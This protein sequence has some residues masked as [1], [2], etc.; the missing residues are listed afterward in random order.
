LTVGSDFVDISLCTNLQHLILDLPLLLLDDLTICSSLRLAE[1]I[2]IA[3]L[4]KIR[5][6]RL[7]E[8]TVRLHLHIYKPSEVMI[9]KLP[10]TYIPDA[11]TAEDLAEFDEV[12]LQI[13]DHF[14]L[15]HISF[16]TQRPSRGVADE[17][18]RDLLGWLCPRLTEQGK[19][20]L[21]RDTLEKSI[22]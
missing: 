10:V 17:D 22:Y 21:V 5:F 7:Q 19:Y 6:P 16:E 1:F 13:L 14:H 15:H 3:S 11:V 18:V 9:Y 4:D 12:L 8:F 20:K 2:S